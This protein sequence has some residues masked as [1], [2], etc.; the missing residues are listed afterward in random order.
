MT[1][2]PGGIAATLQSLLRQWWLVVP[3]NHGQ[4]LTA[5]YVS[6][7]NASCV[8]R[9]WS[10]GVWEWRGVCRIVA[11]MSQTDLSVPRLAPSGKIRNYIPRI[12]QPQ[13]HGGSFHPW[14][15]T[16]QSAAGGPVS[17]PSPGRAPGGPQSP[18]WIQRPRHGTRPGSVTWHCRGVTRPVT[19]AW[20]MSSQPGMQMMTLS[21]TF[22]P[23][24]RRH[25]HRLISIH[26]LGRPRDNF[27]FLLNILCEQ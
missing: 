25:W 6:V 1:P 18:W 22:S 19:R 7:C 21:P 26:W 24:H 4:A 15:S 14:L 27:I 12:P 8:C 5:L 9:C 16:C 20:R 23:G 2:I 13:L 10:W 17:P 11:V 3:C